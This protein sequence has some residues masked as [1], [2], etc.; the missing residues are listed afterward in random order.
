ML[1]ILSTKLEKKKKFRRHF[2]ENG[3]KILSR[4]QIL[5]IKRL[6]GLGESVKK[7]RFATK[8]FFR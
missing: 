3:Q 2:R 6:E 7:G 1:W 5:A 4:L 8:I